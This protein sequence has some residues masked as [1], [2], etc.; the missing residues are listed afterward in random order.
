M[1]NIQIYTTYCGIANREMLRSPFIIFMIAMC[2]RTDRTKAN[3]CFIFRAFPFI[4]SRWFYCCCLRLNTRWDFAHSELS[5]FVGS[6][7]YPTFFSD[8]ANRR[9]Q[10]GVVIVENAFCIIFSEIS[11]T[12]KLK[13]N[14]SRDCV[15]VLIRKWWAFNISDK[16]S[17]LI[18][19]LTCRLSLKK[20]RIRNK[21]KGMLIA[22][23]K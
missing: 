6:G 20:S 13:T 17:K 8:F 2:A 1:Y 7:V 21:L 14:V 23:L 19:L 10:I 18:A 5:I 4:F 16:R 22:A 11:N 3:Y 15:F 9:E 12:R